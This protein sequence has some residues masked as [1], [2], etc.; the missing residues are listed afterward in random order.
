MLLLLLLLLTTVIKHSLMVLNRDNE[1]R[2][3]QE[4]NGSGERHRKQR[5]TRGEIGNWRQP[6]LNT[7]D[8]TATSADGGNLYRMA[9]IFCGEMEGARRQTKATVGVGRGRKATAIAD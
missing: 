9:G 4:R 1:R 6:Q 5:I 8:P 3:D 2:N 7:V